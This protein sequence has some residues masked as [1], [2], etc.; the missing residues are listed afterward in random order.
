MG[1]D[2]GGPGPKPWLRQ[3][4]RGT[5]PVH[6]RDRVWIE[7]RLAWCGQ[8][9]GPATTAPALPGFV[10]QGFDGTQEWAEELVRR[11]GAVMGADVGPI[12]VRLVEPVPGTTPGR[13]HRVGEYREED[14]G[15]VIELDRS[16]AARPDAFAALIAHELA[17]A[18]LAGRPNLA[19]LRLTHAEEERL[20]DL[21]TVFLGMGVLTANAADGYV[22]TAGFTVTPLGGLG[23]WELTGRR[24]EPPHHMGY[25]KPSEFGYALS[26]WTLARGESSPPW[27]GRLVPSVRSA[28]TRGLAYR[29]ARGN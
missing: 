11:V 21:L 18:R 10:P 22:R 25:L 1:S 28:F 14:D 19:G 4:E 8:E 7:R 2:D 27:A 13:R 9:F 24:D 20:T 23:D 12:R 5:S 17:H 6:E 26:C 16:V 29:A 3:Q 15:P